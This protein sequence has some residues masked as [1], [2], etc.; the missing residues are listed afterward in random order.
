MSAASRTGWNLLM[1]IT[2]LF[3]LGPVMLVVLFSFASNQLLGFPLGDLT[4]DWYRELWV[5]D[6]FRRAFWNSL[7][8]AGPVC[9]IST[10]VGSAAAFAI[11]RLRGI[12][13]GLATN[14]LCLPL[15]LP[16]LVLAIA[17]LSFYTQVAGIPLGLATVIAS[18]LVVTQPLVVLVVAARMARFDY[19][20]IDSARDLGADAFTIFAKVTFPIVRSAVIGAAL[21]AASIS[22]DDFIL[23]FFTI[24][25]GN[26][27]PTF[28]WS[29]IR[30]TL[31]PSINAVGTIILLLTMISAALAM[32]VSRYRG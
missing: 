17:L 6:E 26:T 2:V 16:P 25:T 13:P 8:V 18:Q 30:T 31:D 4:L 21:M 22:L 12:W 28:I 15:M 9:L 32:W 7:K 20:L 11:A 10:L 27:L 14:L 29:K 1:G 5:D 3:M 24:G 19:T 23:T